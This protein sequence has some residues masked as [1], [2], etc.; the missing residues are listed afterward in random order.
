MIYVSITLLLSLDSDGEW[1]GVGRLE[2]K[3]AGEADRLRRQARARRAQSGQDGVVQLLQERHPRGRLL[4]P[5]RH[6]VSSK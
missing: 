5:E 1:R 4:R 2:G 6:A 3:G